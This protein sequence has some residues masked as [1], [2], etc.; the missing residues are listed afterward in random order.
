MVPS[1]QG[2]LELQLEENKVLADGFILN[3]DKQAFIP[4]TP[5]LYYKG[6]IAGDDQSSV[7]ISFFDDEVM[8]IISPTGQSN[9][10]IGKSKCITI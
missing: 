3:S 4:Y 2:D 8:G 10:V 6:K 7:A 5:G 9:L 1:F